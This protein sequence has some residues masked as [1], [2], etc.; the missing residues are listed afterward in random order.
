MSAP[1]NARFIHRQT[2]ASAMRFTTTELA[3]LE[4][5]IAGA[6]R[7]RAGDRA[8]RLRRADGRGGRRRRC[9]PRRRRRARRRSTS[10]RPSPCW[11]RRRPT[12]GPM[13]EDSLAFAIAGGRHP[14][15][16]QALRGDGGLSS[17]TIAISAADE[18]AADLAGHRPEHGR[19]VDLPPPERADR[20]PRADRLLRAGEV[21]A[22]RHRRPPVQPG[23]RGRR[24]RPR[25]LDLHGRDGRD[26]RDPQPGRARARSSSSTRSAAAP[27]PST[28]S[29][30]PGRRSSICTRSTAAAPS[31]PPTTT[32]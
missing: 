19:Q 6:A 25:P 20:H 9:D 3:E 12:A 4:A 5:K 31:S 11:P 21:G 26:R 27:R 29:R 32:S 23:R 16:E 22:D 14:V 30:S 2:M 28:A 8:R 13:V 10:P 18:A 1:L 7:P 15:V 24:S 17:P